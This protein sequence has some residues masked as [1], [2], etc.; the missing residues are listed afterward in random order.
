LEEFHGALR[1]DPGNTDLA[2]TI[3]QLENKLQ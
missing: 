3:E 2:Q 1:L